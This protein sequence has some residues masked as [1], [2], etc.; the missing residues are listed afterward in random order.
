MVSYWSAFKELW[1]PESVVPWLLLSIYWLFPPSFLLQ[2]PFLCWIQVFVIGSRGHCC[3]VCV[4]VKL[5]GELCCCCS[6]LRPLC[7][8]VHWFLC[9]PWTC[10]FSSS[11]IIVGLDAQVCCSLVLRYWSEVGS[12]QNKEHVQTFGLF[13]W[14]CWADTDSRLRITVT[15]LPSGLQHLC[16]YR[17]GPGRPEYLLQ[18]V[19]S[20]TF[21]RVKAPLSLS[22]S[23]HFSIH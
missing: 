18:S 14:F 12:V 6:V 5:G 3:S 13:L 11:C 2:G 21:R 20:F 22:A 10:S 15:H 19:S 4:H 9:A 16:K 1:G 23:I 17:P 8:C 7:P